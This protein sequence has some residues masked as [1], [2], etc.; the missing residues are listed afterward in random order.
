ME[1]SETDPTEIV[2]P[3]AGETQLD[4]WTRKCKAALGRARARLVPVVIDTEGVEVSETLAEPVFTD[5]S[6]NGSE[7]TATGGRTL[8]QASAVPSPSETSQDVS[9]WAADG[10]RRPKKT[11]FSSFYFDPDDSVTVRVFQCACGASVAA[12]RDRA[13]ALGWRRTLSGRAVPLAAGE[14]ARPAGLLHGPLKSRWACPECATAPPETAIP[15]PERIAS[16]MPTQNLLLFDARILGVVPAAC[17]LRRAGPKVAEPRDV[18]SPSHRRGFRW[19]SLF[20]P[21]FEFTPR[22][23]WASGPWRIPCAR[24][25]GNQ[26]HFLDP[27]SLPKRNSRC[28]PISRRNKK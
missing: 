28:A 15:D 17:T 13:A 8:P 7:A 3:H 11:S 23:S 25:A 20:S 19:C 12:D 2:G 26:T 18:A 24:S 4:A 1:N 5:S 27:I 14:P 6:G 21:L 9:E 16:E 22:H 10:K